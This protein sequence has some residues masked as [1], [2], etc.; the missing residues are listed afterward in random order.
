MLYGE[1][2]GKPHM[3]D[4]TSVKGFLSWPVCFWFVCLRI[5]A[6]LRLALYACLMLSP[7]CICLIGI[8]CSSWGVP[9]RGTTLRNALNNVLGNV[10]LTKVAKANLMASRF[11]ASIHMKTACC[12]M[13]PCF[14]EK[15]YLRL[16][17]VC[18]TLLAGNAWFV[19]EQPR[20]S[21]LFDYFRW[22][23]LRE[24]V[25]YVSVLH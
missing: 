22:Q 15:I 6:T 5:T 10:G 21:V 19:V 7:G 18:L 1:R 4:F 8:D 23:W 16:V 13:V 11:P 12:W 3:M 20:G 25:T 2:K 9:N 17:L 24:T 14:F